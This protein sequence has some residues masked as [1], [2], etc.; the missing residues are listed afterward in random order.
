M[1]ETDLREVLL[2]RVRFGATQAVGR[3]LLQNASIEQ[4]ADVIRGGFIFQLRTAI[5]AQRLDE[6][7]VRYPADWWQAFKRRFFPNWALRRWPVLETTRVMRLFAWYPNM[8]ISE[9]R[10]QVFVQVLNHDASV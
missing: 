10:S 8:E 4:V 2:E 3:A 6:Q 9:E 1:I 5:Y 7:V